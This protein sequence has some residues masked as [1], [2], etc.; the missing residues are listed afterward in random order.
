[1]LLA[2]RVFTLVIIPRSA[3]RGAYVFS[4]PPAKRCSPLACSPSVLVVLRPREG[5]SGRRVDT[6]VTS[7]PINGSNRWGALYDA[8]RPYTVMGTCGCKVYNQ[9]TRPRVVAHKTLAEGRGLLA[10]WFQHTNDRCSSSTRVPQRIH[11]RDGEC[12]TRHQ[13]R[14]SYAYATKQVA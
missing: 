8:D 7:L 9:R 1:M 5:E 3:H 12:V 10:L 13:R 11:G 4:Q 14:Y 6:F 2:V